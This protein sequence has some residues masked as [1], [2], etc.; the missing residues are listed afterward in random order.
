VELYLYFRHISAWQGAYLNTGTTL[1]FTAKFRL[2]HSVTLTL[3]L[4]IINFI[5]KP[6]VE[7][8]SALDLTLEVPMAKECVV[9]SVTAIA[10]LKIL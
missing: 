1:N 9:D 3:I 10:V 6:M 8:L 2:F 7:S 4:Q 5:A